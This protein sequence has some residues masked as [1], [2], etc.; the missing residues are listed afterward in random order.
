MFLSHTTPHHTTPHHTTPHHTYFLIKFTSRT[1]KTFPEKTTIKTSSKEVTGRTIPYK[2]HEKTE[3]QL[4]TY[5]P[6]FI[7][8]LSHQ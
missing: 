1:L 6:I 7:I 4:K 5:P 3:Q 8:W 2:T